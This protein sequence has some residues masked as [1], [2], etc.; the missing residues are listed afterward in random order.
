[1]NFGVCWI[2]ELVQHDQARNLRDKLHGPSDRIAMR[3]PDVSSTSV[4]KCRSSATLSVD[5]V[6]GIVRMSR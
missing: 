3:M 6:A 4:P 5:V 1:V 2:S